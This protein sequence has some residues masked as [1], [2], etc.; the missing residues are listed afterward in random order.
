MNKSEFD[1]LKVGDKVSANACGWVRAVVTK[2]EVVRKVTVQYRNGGDKCSAEIIY[3]EELRTTE[4]QDQKD[5]AYERFMNS[6]PKWGT[7]PFCPDRQHK[8][9]ETPPYGRI[10]VKCGE[11]DTD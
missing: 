5:R 9:H 11:T 2:V 1:N 6:I 8:W 7:V 4:E 3:P 10:C